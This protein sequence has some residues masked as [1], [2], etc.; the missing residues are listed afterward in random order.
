MKIH[1]HIASLPSFKNAIVTI[2]S[3]DGVHVGH[4]K[5]LD[6]MQAIAQQIGGT[7][8]VITFFPHPKQVVQKVSSPFF[9]LNTI[10]EKAALLSEYGIDHMVIVPFDAQF[11][12]QSATAYIQDFLVG[13]FHPHTIIVGYD[14]KFGNNRTGNFELLQ[15]YAAKFKYQLKEIP[16][17]IINDNTISSSIIRKH[18]QDG[19]IENAN[20]LLGYCYPLSGLVVQGNQLGRTIGFPTANMLVDDQDKLIPADGVYAVDVAIEDIA[21][22]FKGMMNLGSRPT[23]DISEKA[24]EVNIFDFDA[25][26]YGKKITVQ[27]KHKI[28]NTVAFSGKEALIEQLKKDKQIAMAWQ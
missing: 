3:F 5:I 6:Q 1:R 13:C 8:I 11:A 19:M 12:A 9:L 18:L 26:I 16:A 23:F 27:V 22:P 7:T 24:I 15:S 20:A 10:A 4:K 21:K 17:H 25:M 14:H 2:G 28:R